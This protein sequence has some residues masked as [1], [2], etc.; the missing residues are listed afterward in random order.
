MH[1]RISGVKTNFSTKN[2][3]KYYGVHRVSHIFV[4]DNG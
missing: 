4:F 1:K 2:T 3:K